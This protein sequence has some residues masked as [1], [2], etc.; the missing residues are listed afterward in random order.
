MRKAHVFEEN[1]I[2]ALAKVVTQTEATTWRTLLNIT[3]LSTLCTNLAKYVP[4]DSQLE[5]W[6]SMRTHTCICAG[7]GT[8]KCMTSFGSEGT[9]HLKSKVEWL[10][11]DFSVLEH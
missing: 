8:L 7:P 1:V 2:I 5:L 4:G 6:G 9:V 11:R 10:H 3:S